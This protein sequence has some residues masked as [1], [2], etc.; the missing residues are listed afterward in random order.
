[1]GQLQHHDDDSP[2][3]C[4]LCGALAAGPCARCGRPVCGDCCE[5][6]T[7]GVRTFA[8]CLGC[9][10]R[11]GTSLAG[12]WWRVLAWV[13]LPVLVLVATMVAVLLLR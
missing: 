1:M 7:G 10:R 11:G 6:T 5:L 2:E 9:A 3:R 4:R 12:G 8:V 13:G